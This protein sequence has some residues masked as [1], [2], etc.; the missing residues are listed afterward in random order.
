MSI[1]RTV[2]ESSP[3][4]RSLPEWTHVCEGLTDREIG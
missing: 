2:A 4:S 1:E 3:A